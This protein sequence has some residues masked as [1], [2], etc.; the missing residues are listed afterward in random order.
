MTRWLALLR[1]VNVGG[2]GKMIMEDLRAALTEA[3]LQN[4]ESYIASGNIVFEAEA[5]AD[6]LRGLFNNILATRFNVTGERTLLRSSSDMKRVVRMNP[7]PDAVK[8][9]PSDLHVHFL[10]KPPFEQASLNLTSYKGR[11]KL[12]L[13]GQHLY[14]DY[15]NGSGATDLSP[16][17]LETALGTQGTSRNWNTVLKLQEMLQ[18]AAP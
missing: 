12:R 14:I 11:D 1:A 8:F 18:A 7:F 3:G 2:T 13:E 17:F 6:D 9:R 15:A 5:G 16:R 4:V 10:H